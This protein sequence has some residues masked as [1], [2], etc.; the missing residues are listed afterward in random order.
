M[1][2]LIKCSTT[3]ISTLGAQLI[4]T[5]HSTEMGL[6]NIVFEHKYQQHLKY[7]RLLDNYNPENIICPY[8]Y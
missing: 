1:Y 2:K 6:R 4:L 3:V 7:I 8:S 5:E